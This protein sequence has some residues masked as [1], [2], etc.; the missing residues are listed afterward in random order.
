MS[1]SR[2]QSRWPGTRGVHARPCGAGVPERSSSRAL[3][4]IA[5]ASWVLWT[6]TSLVS[7]THLPGTGLKVRGAQC[8]AEPF[9]PQREVSGSKFPPDCGCLRGV[10]VWKWEWEGF[11]ERFLSQPRPCLPSLRCLMGFIGVTQPV[12]RLPSIPRGNSCRCS[13]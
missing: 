10:A 1:P 4:Q 2:A 13:C 6:R 7:G 5:T 12:F 3:S 9:A 11:M 8:E